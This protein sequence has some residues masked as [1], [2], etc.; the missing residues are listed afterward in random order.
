M[1]L[2]S[3]VA[4]CG[5]LLT[6]LAAALP[7]KRHLASIY[8]HTPRNESLRLLAK[9]ELDRKA[10]AMPLDAALTVLH[11]KRGVTGQ[12]A[13]F[14][15]ETLRA[16]KTNGIAGQVQQNLRAAKKQE[17]DASGIGAAETM[18]SEMITQSELKLDTEK[19]RCIEFHTTQGE[20]LEETR[21]TIAQAQSQYA[22]GRAEKLR[23]T[24]EI[25]FIDGKQPQIIGELQQHN[26]QCAEDTTALEAQ[27]AVV[28]QDIQ[29][30]EVILNMSKCAGDEALFLQDEKVPCCKHG[31]KTLSL[32]MSRTR[33]S[34][35]G[36]LRSPAARFM[37]QKAFPIKKM[38][39]RAPGL[40]L[41]QGSTDSKT[42]EYF[43][44]QQ[45]EEMHDRLSTTPMPVAADP[46]CPEESQGKCT[47]ADSPAC[48]RI[49]NKFLTIHAGIVEKKR[50]LEGELEETRRFCKET[51]ESM[52]GEIDDLDSRRTEEE[53]NVAKA[54]GEI[55]EAE[56]TLRVMQRRQVE[57]QREWIAQLKGTT[58]LYEEQISYKMVPS[59]GE[60]AINIHEYEAEICGLKKI[61]LE[62]AKLEGQEIYNS[63]VIDCE[64]GEWTEGECSK[65]CGGGTLKKTRSITVN[66]N[67]EGAACPPL[68]IE[69]VCNYLP[70]PVDCVVGEWAEWSACSASCA[71]GVMERVRQ[72]IRHP[73]FEGQPCDAVTEAE[74][75]NTQSCDQNCELG[76]WC[77]W[78]DCDKVCGGG[79]QKRIRPVAKEATGEGLCYDEEDEPYRLQFQPCNTQSCEDTFE[80]NDTKPFLTCHSKVDVML[81]MDG[82]GSLG[83][84]GWFSSVDA[85]K[86]F[87]STL[88]LSEDEVELAM[89]L[90][91]GPSNW[92]RLDICMGNRAAPRNWDEMKQCNMEWVSHFTDDMTS[93]TDAIDNL[94]WPSG[95]TLTAKALGMAKEELSNGRED[96]EPV[97][98][99]I[100]DGEPTDE[101]NVKEAA[102]ELK[103][104]GARVIW[105]LVGSRIQAVYDKVTLWASVPAHENIIEVANT[106]VLPDPATINAII[107]DFC[108]VLE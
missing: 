96:A 8:E 52:E 36:Q 85:A 6:S 55:N 54:T 40:A 20:A 50:Q 65:P 105:V 71:T 70:C 80:L 108:T 93:V 5:A 27:L 1:K 28:N 41:E 100:T 23:A 12:L 59:A 30:M 83:E 57:L 18:L 106:T 74:S 39:F 10:K 103:R 101:D 97:I 45:A 34:P 99:I 86:K 89:L 75:C 95:T 4:L 107:S 35:L 43:V 72:I 102:D 2:T 77:E 84:D 90:F 15:E 9:A 26:D 62:L 73:A 82:S 21:Q 63:D 14:I 38:S 56:G 46:V 78:T 53:T 22:A 79:S 92:R 19:E 17:P 16:N 60:C 61:R 87:T 88:A 94:E 76:E 3:V 24:A 29:V 37:A 67:D 69:E 44:L 91:S 47:I 49:Q 13:A 81:I 11:G 48:P 51:K 33:T 104:A 98:V 31:N 64:V 32:F 58:V 66:P 7:Q 42:S 25:T 68:E